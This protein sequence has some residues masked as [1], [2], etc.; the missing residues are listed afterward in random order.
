M[1]FSSE[2]FREI[3]AALRSL[4][5]GDYNWGEMSGDWQGSLS[6]MKWLEQKVSALG[7]VEDKRIFIKK[8]CSFQSLTRLNPPSAPDKDVFVKPIGTWALQQVH[9][10]SDNLLHPIVSGM[11]WMHCACPQPGEG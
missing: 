3:D 8:A 6:R 7:R 11:G 9:T 5:D 2:V 1:I 4:R 10:Q